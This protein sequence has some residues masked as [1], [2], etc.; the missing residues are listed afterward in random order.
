MTDTFAPAYAPEPPM[1]RKTTPRVLS[2]KFGDGYRQEG[3]DGLNVLE[4]SM[5][6]SWPLLSSSNAD[7]IE[8]FFKDRKGYVAFYWTP[9]GEASAS[10]W[11]C[12][13]W[14]R[15]AGDGEAETMT[16]TFEQVFDV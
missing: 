15:A 13:G 10:K 3:A 1:P 16:A 9:P 8:G 7:D 11:K 4:R 6:L 2:A 5:D 12:T 14:T